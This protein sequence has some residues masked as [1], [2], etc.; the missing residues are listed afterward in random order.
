MGGLGNK[1]ATKDVQFQVTK[2]L[3]FIEHLSNIDNLY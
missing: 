3:F 2:F 1:E